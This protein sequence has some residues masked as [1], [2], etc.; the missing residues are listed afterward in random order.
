MLA[1]D[2]VRFRTKTFPDSS[3]NATT[4]YANVTGT[5]SAEFGVYYT[6]ATISH[7]WF[8]LVALDRDG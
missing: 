6:A 4:P 3:Y 8:G 5:W 7:N 1:A 2:S